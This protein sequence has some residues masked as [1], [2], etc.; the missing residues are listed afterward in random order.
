MTETWTALETARAVRARDVSAREVLEQTLARAEERGSV[1]AF[2]HLTGEY[3]AAQAERIDQL[4]SRGSD[5]GAL[6]GV[7]FPIKDLT[8]V[9]GLPCEYGSATLVGHVAKVSDGVVLKAEAA[10]T[11]TVGKTTT[12][13]FG[14]PAY[15]EPV[16]GPPARTPWD[17][18]RIAG[19]SSGGAAA[20]VASGIVP[21][22][23]ATDGGGSIRIPSACCGTV[24]LKPSR[25]VISP[26][27]HATYGAGLTTDGVISRTVADT[28]T[29]LDVLSGPWPGDA[30]MPP[31]DQFRDRAGSYAGAARSQIHPLKIGF[32]TEPLNVDS[33][34]LHPQARRAAE[35]LGRALEE[36]GHHVEPVSRPITS[37]QWRAFMPLWTGA[38]AAMD[39]DED[40]ESTIVELSR[41]LREEGQSL[42]GADYAVAVTEVQRLGQRISGAWQGYDLILTPTLSGPP[43][44]PA[45]I[46]LSHGRDDFAAQC[47]LT[48]WG[49]V[50]NMVGWPSITLP[51]HSA[52]VDGVTL[53]FGAMLS[54]TAPGQDGLLLALAADV[55]RRIPFPG[56]VPITTG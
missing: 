49:S 31:V 10:G 26:G 54:G 38:A 56:I 32:L 24:G 45:D 20:A 39:L 44:F 3:A 40:G 5:P 34:D 43:P 48:P 35:I 7:P 46:V 53:P 28:A 9:R 13:E 23:H 15:T 11:L 16:T 37:E 21:V 55:E 27:P 6:A 18:R 47:D 51:V 33:I 22:A 52:P 2:A 42:T 14:F 8:Q 41:W 30:W 17:I 4:I 25:G 36:A 12:P 50:W 19:G 29:F 1:G